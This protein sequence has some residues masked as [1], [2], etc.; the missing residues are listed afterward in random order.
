MLKTQKTKGVSM[1]SHEY[2]RFYISS[3]IKIQSLVRQR[4]WYIPT[5]KKNIKPLIVDL[6][7]RDQKEYE[8]DHTVFGDDSIK[9]IKMLEIA[10]KQR[11]KQMKEGELA[12]III[13]NW[14][15]WEDLGIGHPTGLDCRK[16]DNSII[17]ELKNKYNTCNSGSQ[18]A[19]LD[20]LAKYKKANPETRCIWGIINS[21]KGCRRLSQKIIHEGVEIEKIQGIDLLRLIFKVGNINYSTQLINMVKRVVSEI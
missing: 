19:L 18:K 20:K 9:N 17:M 1:T 8:H 16:K 13:G 5:F 12:Q 10:F 3:I 11:Q 4:Y 2:E 21:K 15:G 7:S 6:Y 14:I